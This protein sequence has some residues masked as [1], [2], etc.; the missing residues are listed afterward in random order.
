VVII[1]TAGMVSLNPILPAAAA[2]CA[3]GLPVAGLISQRLPLGQA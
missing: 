2:G 1:L 3:P